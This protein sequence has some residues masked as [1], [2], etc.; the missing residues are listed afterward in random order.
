MP[1]FVRLY[2]VILILFVRL[3]KVILILFVRL[4]S[5]LNNHTKNGARIFYVLRAFPY[6]ICSI[7]SHPK[8]VPNLQSNLPYPLIH[9]T[10][11]P[12][13]LVRLLQLTVPLTAGDV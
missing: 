2:K 4:Y 13:R 10:Y 1:T 6:N 7:K 5:I 8:P 3:Y 11:E 9:M 12:S